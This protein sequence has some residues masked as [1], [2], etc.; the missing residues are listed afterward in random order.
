MTPIMIARPTAPRRDFFFDM[1]GIS[2]EDR[3]ESWS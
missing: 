1:F 2:A 3:L